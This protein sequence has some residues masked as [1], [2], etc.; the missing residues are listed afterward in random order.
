MQQPSDPILA[1]LEKVVSTENTLSNLRP[2]VARVQTELKTKS[3]E[4]MTWESLPPS[5]FGNELPCQLASIWIF[6]IRAGTYLGVERHPNSYQRTIA[7]HGGGL[8]EL[9]DNGAWKPYP[10]SSIGEER[11]VS[12]P[13]NTWHRVTAG[14][15]DWAMIS[16]HTV[17]AA[18]LIEEK[19]D[20]EDDLSVTH[21]R[22]Y[23]EG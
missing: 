18:E 14:P 20:N 2:I 23:E 1:L 17:P 9:Y 21:S 16:F 7:L 12:I 22:R 3:N 19:P 15:E 6:A 13:Q 5:F 8:F 10:V 11:C 4:P